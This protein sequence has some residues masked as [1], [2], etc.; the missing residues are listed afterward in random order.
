MDSVKW[1]TEDPISEVSQDFDQST[2]S[3]LFIFLQNLC[4]DRGG[5]SLKSHDKFPEN[6]NPSH[7]GC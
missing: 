1:Q 2:L 3:S 5:I 7:Y 4:P 6:N